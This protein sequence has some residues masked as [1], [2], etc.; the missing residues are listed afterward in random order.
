MEKSSSIKNIANA[1]LVFHVKV[2]KISKDANNPFF[3]SKYASLSNILESIQDA[4]TESGLSFVQFP[5]GEHELTTLL[6]HAESGEYTQGTYKMTP[7]DNTPQGIGSCITYQKRYALAAILGLNI[8]EDD[9]GN[10]ATGLK[11]GKAET[12][13]VPVDD[14][15]WLN[16]GTKEFEGAVK[17]LE[18]GTTT[19]EKIEAVFKLSKPI[20]AKL[21]SHLQPA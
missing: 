2:D 13:G 4:L 19:I 7:K 9:D 20:K 12:N 5:E 1:L 16:E 15:K 17:K 14:K 6:M 21:L 3:K 10:K 11:E 8:D 18:A